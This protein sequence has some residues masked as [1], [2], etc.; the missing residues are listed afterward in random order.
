MNK[1]EIETDKSTYYIYQISSKHL[2]LNDVFLSK[3]KCISKVKWNYGNYKHNTVVKQIFESEDYEYTILE[4]L[5]TNNKMELHNKVLFWKNHAEIYVRNKNLFTTEQRYEAVGAIGERAAFQLIK[6][7]FGGTVLKTKFRYT[8]FDFYDETY[9]FEYKNRQI[10]SF[11]FPTVIINKCKIGIDRNMIFIF[12][13]IDKVFY[14]RYEKEV[15]DSFDIEYQ[16]QLNGILTTDDVVHIP[17]KFLTEINKDSRIVLPP[18]YT[19]KSDIENRIDLIEK[20][21]AKYR[22]Y[23]KTMPKM[24]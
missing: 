23:N 20:D 1:N 24:I 18:I 12:Q 19:D 13:Y 9:L 3:L 7:V 16:K 14:I 15:F 8:K 4:T 10:F 2:N 11:Q 6:N 5:Q 22:L 21:E 17:R